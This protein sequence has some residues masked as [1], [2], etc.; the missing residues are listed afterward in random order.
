MQGVRNDEVYLLEDVRGLLVP[1]AA[2]ARQ[3]PDGALA[4]PH[5]TASPQT[6]RP[7]ATA[8]DLERAGQE[9]FAAQ[10]RNYFDGRG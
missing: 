3:R 7:A 6:A 1:E 9:R 2:P 10:R 8:D 5:N 4:E